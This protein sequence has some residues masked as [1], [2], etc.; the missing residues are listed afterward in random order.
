MSNNENWR[1][2]SKCAH[3]GRC[4]ACTIV[5]FLSLTIWAKNPYA[6]SGGKSN[7]FASRAYQGVKNLLGMDGTKPP[8]SSFGQE[9]PA[10]DMD[11]GK[12]NDSFQDSPGYKDFI[13]AREEDYPEPEREINWEE[14]NPNSDKNWPYDKLNGSLTQEQIVSEVKKRAFLALDDRIWIRQKAISENRKLTEEEKLKDSKL[15]EI[16]KINAQHLIDAAHLPDIKSLTND[17][18]W[19]KLSN[20]L[21]H[22]DSIVNAIGS[23]K[24]KCDTDFDVCR[25]AV[26]DDRDFCCQKCGKM[27]KWLAPHK[28]KEFEQML[29]RGSN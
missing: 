12:V 1:M 17:P 15:S 4:I 2:I 6:A 14:G 7:S 11:N 5:S 26:P 20:E 21:A 8:V 24:R 18:K 3:I 23:K 28:D 27:S 16:I 22:K 9:G 25:C 29:N 10:F 19:K 13:K